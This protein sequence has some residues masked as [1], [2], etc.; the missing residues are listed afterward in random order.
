MKKDQKY[1][2]G[3]S[4]GSQ[5][6]K[7]LAIFKK[8]RLIIT[9][10]AGILGLY[11][12]FLQLSGVEV[13][14][15]INDE[16]AN[17]LMKIALFIYYLAWLNGL[18]MDLKDEEAIFI[19]PPNKGKFTASAVVM[20]LCIAIFFFLLCLFKSKQI[21]ALFLD[22][23][24][25]INILSW[26]FLINFISDSVKDNKEFYNSENKHFKFIYLRLMVDDYLKGSWQ[27]W[28]FGVGV[29]ILIGLNILVFTDLAQVISTDLKLTSVELVKAIVFILFILVSEGWIWYMRLQRRISIE[30][31]DSLDEEYYLAKR[32]K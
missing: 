19:L 12:G 28:R 30:L 32:N 1:L 3:V 31:I 9:I 7:Q 27:W 24:M 11:Y 29:V 22:V 10:I 2:D 23:F 5:K 14:P 25:I 13:G 16:F 15:F 18:L 21:F 4:L 17:V 26:R 6:K 20:I 8:T